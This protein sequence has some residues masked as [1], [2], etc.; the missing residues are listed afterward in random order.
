M[1][2]KSN[3][4]LID[5]HAESNG[6]HDSLYL[7]AHKINDHQPTSLPPEQVADGNIAG[8]RATYLVFIGQ[9]PLVYLAPS[10]RFQISVVGGHFQ[11]TFAQFTGQLVAV[12]YGSSIYDSGLFCEP[13]LK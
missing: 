4:R 12:F 1:Y 11:F 9:P 13:L 3:V 8:A 5:P 10:G 6:R 2:D 7:H